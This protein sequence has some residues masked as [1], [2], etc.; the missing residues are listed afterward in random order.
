MAAP[1]P[2]L[3]TPSLSIPSTALLRAPLTPPPPTEPARTGRLL[4]ADPASPIPALAR[5]WAVPRSALDAYAAA[6]PT[7]SWAAFYVSIVAPVDDSLGHAPDARLFRVLRAT[8]AASGRR[9]AGVTRQSLENVVESAIRRRASP[10]LGRNVAAAVASVVFCVQS[11]RRGGVSAAAVRKAGLSAALRRYEVSNEVWGCMSGLEA[12]RF[13]AMLTDLEGVL[14]DGR[15]EGEGYGECECEFSAEGCEGG[16]ISLG[17]VLRYCEK[18]DLLTRRAV[19]AVFARHGRRAV[20]GRCGGKCI[21]DDGSVSS[22]ESVVLEGN[23]VRA[24]DGK[25]KTRRIGGLDTLAAMDC[26]DGNDSPTSMGSEIDGEEGCCAMSAHE[27]SETETESVDEEVEECLI[28]L[29]QCAESGADL[30]MTAL[31]FVRLY[32]ALV[33]CGTDTG[34]RYWFSV[35]DVDGDGYISCADGRHFYGERRRDGERRGGGDTV[36]CEV[37]SVWTRVCGSAGG[38]GS[39]QRRLSIGEV[40]GMGKSDREFLLCALLIRRV[41]DVQLVDVAATD[42]LRKQNESLLEK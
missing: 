35:L 3:P 31:D 39:P 21:S 42:R 12:G 23:C 36:L 8:D 24:V 34:V 17:S 1:I 33:R 26:G 22:V 29:S 38:F 15:R 16:W 4:A 41:D 37:E 14:G 30:A 19:L 28:T 27:G 32:L 18:R 5:L 20:V 6:D 9:S 11:D 2:H 25:G 7:V 40:L 10:L 13:G